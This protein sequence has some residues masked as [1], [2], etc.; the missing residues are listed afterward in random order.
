MFNPT[1]IWRR[2]HRRVAWS[3]FG[4]RRG[5]LLPLH[6]TRNISCGTQTTGLCCGPLRLPLKSCHILLWLANLSL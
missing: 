6:A 3:Q 5:L 2:W 4:G 1:R